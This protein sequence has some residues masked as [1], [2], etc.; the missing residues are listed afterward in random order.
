MVE[1]I[2]NGIKKEKNMPMIGTIRRGV[3]MAIFTYKTGV[4][5]IALETAT[6]RFILNQDGSCQV[7]M[8]AAEIGQGG[9]LQYLHKWQQMN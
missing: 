5:P 4:Y 6:V 1:S 8:G 2:F 7:Q 3:G 9:T